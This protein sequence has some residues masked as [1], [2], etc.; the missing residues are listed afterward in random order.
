MY[1]SHGTSGGV[2]IAFEIQRVP[3]IVGGGSD[4]ME[5]S[6]RLASGGEGRLN[7]WPARS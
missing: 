2:K 7:G 4:R 3:A 6:R 5:A 1:T